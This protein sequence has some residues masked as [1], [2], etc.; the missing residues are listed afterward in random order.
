MGMDVYGK[1]PSADAGEYFRNTVWWWHPLWDYVLQLAPWVAAKA[2]LGH[3]NDGDGLDATDSARLAA[4]LSEELD[5]GRTDDYATKYMNALNAIPDEACWLCRGTGVR[6]DKIGRE[7]GM[8]ERGW[9]NGCGGK[10][11]DRPHD[12]CYPFS[13]ENVA[14]FRDFVAASGGFEIC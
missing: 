1:Q 5:A 10:G 2:P 8:V 14:E 4:I 6:S 3:Y 9:C 12:A 11:H 7:A 13:A